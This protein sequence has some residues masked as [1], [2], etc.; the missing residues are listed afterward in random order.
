MSKAP[1]RL[2]HLLETQRLL[3]PHAP[4]LWWQGD[5]ISYEHFFQL[6]MGVAHCVAKCSDQGARVAILAWNSPQY[7]AFLYGV[8]AAGRIVVPL[9]ARLAPAEL[10]HQLRQADASVLVTI[11]EL[12]APL[13]QDSSFPR[14]LKLLNI[15]DDLRSDASE[16]ALSLLPALPE[17]LPQAAWILYTSGSTGRP[18]GAVLTHQSLLAV[19]ESAVQQRPVTAKDKYLFPFPLF[20]VTTH[21]ILLQHKYGACVVLHESF[22]AGEVLRSIKKLQVTNIS[23]APTMI[24]MLV[25]QPD[26]DPGALESVRTIGYGASAM[27]QTLL[28]QIM[29]ETN[30]GLCQ[31][32]GMTELSGSITYLNEE[33][34]RRAARDS[35]DVLGSA[36]KPVDGVEICLRDEQGD[37][38]PP[39]ESGEITVKAAQC[40]LEYWRQPDATADTLHE[41]WL[42]TGDIGRFDDNGYL[43]IVDRKKDIII[44]GGENVASKEVEEILRLHAAVKEVAVIGIADAKWGEIVCA[45]VELEDPTSSEELE[46]HCRR[47]LAGYKTPK[48]FHSVEKIPINANGKIDKPALR[49]NFGKTDA[50]QLN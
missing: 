15:L 38:C 21:N 41:G 28:R 50:S 49:L 13:Q 39:G 2:H 35:P 24:A 23:L 14:D 32:Y 45:M 33:Q 47:Y 48:R 29:A 11:P 34:H 22:D 30:V 5:Y 27:P 26:F 1:T 17:Q 19:L 31:G 10:I 6:V 16:I 7:M 25:D 20:H 43:Y 42:Y 18:K 4:A 3:R 46:L 40:M 44:S 8:P 12:A 9:N 37:L 36:G